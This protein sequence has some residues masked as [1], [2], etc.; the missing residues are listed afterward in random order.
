MKD[1]KKIKN[2]YISTSLISFVLGLFLV[3]KPETSGNIISYI[4]GACFIFY[5]IVHIV[6]YIIVKNE[7]FYQYD[8]AKGIITVSIGIFFILRPS[9]IISIL[10]T[11]LGFAILINGIFGI[12]SS[13][14][15][16]RAD[17]KKWLAVFIPAIITIVLGMLILINP[18]K[19]AQMLLVIIGGCLIWN[20]VSNFWTHICIAKKFKEIQTQQQP[21]DTTADE[22]PILKQDK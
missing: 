12:Q 21:I 22:S 19:W 20:G 14:N 10:P 5:G 1:V 15:M 3:L 9:F 6:T 16:L 7:N 18:F 4:L 8:L 13:I 17:S 11:I 2:A